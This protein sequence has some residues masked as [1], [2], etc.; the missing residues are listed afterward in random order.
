MPTR[1]ILVTGG[2]GFIGSHLVD[3][4]IEEGHRVRV[5]DNFDKQVHGNTKP[6][7]LNP[8]AEYIELDIRNRDKLKRCI[9]N[10]DAIFHQAAVVGVGQSTYQIERY[11]DNNIR[12]TAALLD[13]LANEK[14]SVK[15]IIVAS[16]MSIYG[17]GSYSCPKCVKVECKIRNL[18][19]LKKRIW[20][21]KCPNCGRIVKSVAT[22][23]S[24]QL[25]PTSIYALTKL[26]QE[27]ITLLVGK[28]YGIAAVALRYFNV[29]GPRQALSN[30]Y[31]GVCAIFSSRIKCNR[32]PLI[33][34][35]GLQTRDFI[36][37]K[38]IVAANLL[39]L[40]N[41]KAD[42]GYFNVGTGEAVSILTIA[43]LLTK[44]YKKTIAPKI[45]NKYRIGD[46]RHCYSDITAI[47]KLGF[48]PTVKLEDGLKELVAWGINE[49][50][51]DLSLVANRELAKRRLRF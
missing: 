20:E 16:S 29:Y 49:E 4:L 38:D 14:N 1:R 6:S 7:H 3:K 28:T 40:N 12:G 47:K 21:M 9:K 32:E 41:S 48:K 50:A 37:V 25:T 22:G 11:I 46:I 8:E 18:E 2:A 27:Q 23:E 43:Q 10:I 39:V 35:D 17:E 13:V 42:Y 15:K 34:E 24:K 30:P 19:Q 26:Q 31:T 33:Y 44:L 51:R 45:I 36:N 5:V